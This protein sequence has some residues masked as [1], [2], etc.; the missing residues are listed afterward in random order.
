MLWLLVKVG[1]LRACI[2]KNTLA[3]ARVAQ[4][5][6]ITG[7]FFLA[8]SSWPLKVTCSFIGNCD[9]HVH[10]LVMASYYNC[11]SYCRVKGTCCSTYEIIIFFSNEHI[12]AV[13]AVYLH[14]I[15]SGC[16]PARDLR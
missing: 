14:I 2:V 3:V 9:I 11:G 7:S 12:F 8:H 6:H 4:I 1:M 10:N 13:Y 16:T 15:L 5:F